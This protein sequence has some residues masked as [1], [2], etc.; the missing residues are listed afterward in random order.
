MD[1]K[2]LFGEDAL[3]YEQ[4]T[5][6]ITEQGI[7]LADL[8]TSTYVDKGKLEKQIA[9]NKELQAKYDE[10]AKNT[11]NYEAITKELNELKE[12]KVTNGYFEQIR[13]AKVDD[14]FSKFVLSEI[15]GSMKEG[16]KFEDVL[17]KY[18]KEN[19]QYLMAKQGAVQFNSPNLENG[20][21]LPTKSEN[22][23]INDLIRRRN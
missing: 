21:S 3:N 10:L 20:G 2:A 8:S 7:K 13:N 17:G 16:E 6:K 22:E 1:L 4:F 19:P 14:K 5:A 23:I 12:E 11:E 9:S 18:V 15:R